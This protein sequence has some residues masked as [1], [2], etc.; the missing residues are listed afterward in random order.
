[1]GTEMQA[2]I[3]YDANEYNWRQWG[4][5]YGYSL[6]PPFEDETAIDTLTAYHDGMYTGSKDYLFFGAVAG[7]RNRTDIPPLYPLRGTPT[8]MNW[9]TMIA[10]SQGFEPMGWLTLQEINAALDH[11]NVNRNRLGTQ[12]LVILDIME[13]LERRFG[14]DRARLIFHIE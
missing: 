13:V 7:I 14:I 6:C 2:F 8:N 4:E 9:R 11:Q 10:V 3:E 5:S 12:T 1:M